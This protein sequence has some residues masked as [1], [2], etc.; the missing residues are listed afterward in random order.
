MNYLN[1]LREARVD[2][3]EI[4]MLTIIF[5]SIKI[6]MLVFLLAPLA[7]ENQALKKEVNTC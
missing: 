4:I 1:K 3:D 5:T 6:H 2:F 7:S